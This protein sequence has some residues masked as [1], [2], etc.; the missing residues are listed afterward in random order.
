MRFAI[1]RLRKAY[2]L[3]VWWRRL[4][5]KIRCVFLGHRW[6]KEAYWSGSWELCGRCHITRN[7]KPWPTRTTRW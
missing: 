7:H 6:V 5:G 2:K 4:P 3:R 1:W